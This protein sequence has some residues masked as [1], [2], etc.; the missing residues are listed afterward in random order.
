MVKKGDGM[1]FFKN[2]TFAL[3]AA[4]ILPSAGL[5]QG[6]VSSSGV[7][8]TISEGASAYQAAAITDYIANI[9]VRD[10]SNSRGAR[11]TNFAAVIQQDRANLHNTGIA[12]GEGM[13]RDTLDGYF[14]SPARRSAL[15]AAQYYTDCYM[16]PRQTQDL[17]DAILNARVGGVLWVVPF[18]RPDGGLGVYISPAS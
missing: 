8:L 13:L 15:S 6:C 10:L 5:A 3:I 2:N 18:N 11:L 17:K 4:L 9:D 12:D 14:T 16:S 7:V 1:T